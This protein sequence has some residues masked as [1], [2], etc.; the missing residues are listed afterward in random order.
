MSAALSEHRDRQRITSRGWDPTLQGLGAGN[1]SADMLMAGLRVPYHPTG[2]TGDPVLVTQRYLFQ[3][4]SIG[5][6]D[7][8][9]L[10]SLGQLSVLGSEQYSGGGSPVPP[11]FPNV[12]QQTSSTFRFAD[13]LPIR[14]GVRRVRKPREL[15]SGMTAL[16]TNSFS[17]GWTDNSGLIFE[18]ATFGLLN[19]DWKGT[20]DN[21]L[22]VQG[23]TAPGGGGVF[24]GEPVGGDL[25]CFDSPGLPLGPRRGQVVLRA[26]VGQARRAA[27]VLRAR[28]SDRAE[29]PRDH[30][31]AG[32]VS[33][34]HHGDARERVHRRLA[35]HHPV[36]RGRLDAGREARHRRRPGRQAGA[37]M[38][39][40]TC[41]YKINATG[42]RTAAQL[43][44]LMDA[45][46]V[47]IPADFYALTGATLISDTTAVLGNQAIR[48]VVF[49]DVSAEFLQNFPSNPLD[50]FFGLLKGP[51][52]A[53]VNCTCIESLPVAA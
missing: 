34:A 53:A 30:P 20:P 28:G 40:V 50:P 7:G 44:V 8:L 48:T 45:V 43:S 15:R 16:S 27:G 21:Y 47:P 35:L 49:G 22:T 5:I 4:C 33:A 17:C 6:G 42:T 32:G 12:I 37:R 51:I 39:T 13:C 9:W 10:T 38:A 46:S 41:K 23:Y 19:L 3:L 11:V 36:L 14:W 2:I 31:G 18:T 52:D 29:Q 26:G 24:P 1:L 25:G